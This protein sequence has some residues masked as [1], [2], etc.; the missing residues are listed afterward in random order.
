MFCYSEFS[1][2]IL[3]GTFFSN[4][5]PYYMN[6][7]A[8]GNIIGNAIAHGF[9]D[10]G[11]QF[12]K[13]DWWDA[14]TKSKYLEKTKCIVSQYDNYTA[15]EVGLKVKEKKNSFIENGCTNL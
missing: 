6:Y 7:G 10:R 12:D 2:G 3:Q 4:D 1:A 14:E 8:I 11:R 15:E 5:R 9:D 13:I